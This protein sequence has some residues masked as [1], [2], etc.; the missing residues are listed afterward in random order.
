MLNRI[1]CCFES[2]GMGIQTV[3]SCLSSVIAIITSIGMRMA[4]K[5][6]LLSVSLSFHFVGFPKFPLD[7][8]RQLSETKIEPII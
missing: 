3:K 2:N 5:I 1:W 4:E 6:Y 8:F 7:F